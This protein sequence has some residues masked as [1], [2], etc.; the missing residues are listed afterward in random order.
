MSGFSP[1][2]TVAVTARVNPSMTDT[3]YSPG[4]VT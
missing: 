1:M 4:W 3:E 2:G